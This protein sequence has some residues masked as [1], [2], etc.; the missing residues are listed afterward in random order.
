MK[1]WILTMIPFSWKVKGTCYQQLVKTVIS[2]HK[3]AFLK[4]AV[5][6]GMMV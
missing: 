2:K 5:I 4:E 1:V 6:H 3:I